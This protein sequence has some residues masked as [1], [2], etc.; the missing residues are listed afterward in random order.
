MHVRTCQVAISNTR[1]IPDIIIYSLQSLYLKMVLTA[2]YFSPE[3]SPQPSNIVQS[4]RKSLAQGHSF[5]E[6]LLLSV[7]C[8]AR[9]SLLNLWE[10]SE[11]TPPYIPLTQWAYSSCDLLC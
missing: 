2:F 6:A 8:H 7:I 4:G 3:L 10:F 9:V 1:R 5:A 11:S